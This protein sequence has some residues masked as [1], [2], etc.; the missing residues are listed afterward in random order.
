MEIIGQGEVA[1]LEIIKD[2][3]GNSCEYLTQVKLSDMVTPE[4]LDTFS[5]RQLKETID[6]VVDTGFQYLAIRVQDKHHSSARMATIDNI[7]KLMLEWNG[8]KVIDIWHYE[9]EE[10]W[11]DKVNKKSRLELELAIK[12]SSID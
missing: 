7:Q 4:Y 11:K 5:D 10:L 9:C 12:E 8:W 6:I 3:F 2:M 1:A